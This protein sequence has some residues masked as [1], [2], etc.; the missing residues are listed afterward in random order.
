MPLKE[1]LG[2]ERSAVRGDVWSRRGAQRGSVGRR[3][4]GKR[5]EEEMK[6]LGIM[7]EFLRAEGWHPAPRAHTAPPSHILSRGIW[8][9]PASQS[10]IPSLGAAGTGPPL[11][12]QGPQ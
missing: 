8:A 2:S 7:E 1:L 4:G 5:K 6:R 11:A 9:P 12:S 10:K 3:A